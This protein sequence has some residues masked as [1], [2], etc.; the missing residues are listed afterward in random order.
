MTQMTQIELAVKD[1]ESAVMTV[2]QYLR[3]LCHLWL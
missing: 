2:L 3:N 1:A